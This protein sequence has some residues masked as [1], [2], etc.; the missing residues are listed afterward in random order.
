[1]IIYLLSLAAA[2]RKNKENPP[3]IMKAGFGCGMLLTL[4]V[5]RQLRNFLTVDLINPNLLSALSVDKPT[6]H[7]GQVLSI[8]ITRV[9]L[10][11]LTLNGYSFFSLTSNSR[12][13][14]KYPQDT[15][16]P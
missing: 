2:Q 4:T 12:Y 15:Q 10:F 6:H 16:S 13:S 14:G 8:F 9:M 7:Y 1:M 3:R 11:N 5:H